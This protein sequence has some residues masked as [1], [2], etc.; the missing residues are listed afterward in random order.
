[1]ASRIQVTERRRDPND[2]VTVVWVLG[3]ETRMRLNPQYHHP[4]TPP[5]HHT[6]PTPPKPAAAA[7]AAT[8]GT[9]SS[10]HKRR[11]AGGDEGSRPACL[12]P[13]TFFFFFFDYINL[14]LHYIPQETTPY[15]F[16]RSSCSS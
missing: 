9:P 1:M 10:Q 11:L 6:I 5:H 7:A 2:G 12:D 15:E 16:S 14:C 8:A 13:L 3:L 4:T